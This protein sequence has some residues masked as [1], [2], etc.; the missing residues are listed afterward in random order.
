MP[1]R[2]GRIPAGAQGVVGGLQ[3]VT[4]EFHADDALAADADDDRTGDQGVIYRNDKVDGT[5]GVCA[6]EVADQKAVDEELGR[7]HEQGQH[8]GYDEFDKQF[9]D[10]SPGEFFFSP[11]VCP[12]S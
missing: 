6:D 1:W 11:G 12:G 7:Q 3:V 8:A 10:I 5:H 9:G 4:A 2:R